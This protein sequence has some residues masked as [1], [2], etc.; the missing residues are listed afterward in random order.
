MAQT[1]GI[2]VMR[3]PDAELLPY[4]F[5]DF[6][7]TMHK[8]VDE[9]QKLLKD[10]QEKI[11]EQ[12]KE[13]EEGLF[14]ATA[15]PK[16][17]SVPPSMEEVPPHLAFAALQNASDA[18][19]RSADHYQKGLDKLTKDGSLVLNGAVSIEAINTKLLQS[20]RKLTSGDGLPGRP[21]FKHMVYA[22]GYYTGYGVKTIPG[23]REA[24]EQKK[25]KEADEQIARIAQVLQDEAVLI[26]SAAGELEGAQK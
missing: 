17:K 4:D 1:V 20:E 23:V 10:K 5:T 21:W 11:S 22:P 16:E 13:L 24:I 7:D 19:T 2:S 14:S 25:W 12:N 6:A 18:L 8:Y 15:D 9:L 26:D 3:L